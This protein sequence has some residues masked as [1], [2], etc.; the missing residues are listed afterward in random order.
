MKVTKWRMGILTT[1]GAL[2]LS[3]G[4]STETSSYSPEQMINNALEEEENPNY[5]GESLMEIYDNGEMIEKMRMKEWR[6]KD[7]KIR[8]ETTDESEKDKVIVVNDGQTITTYDKKEKQ[9]TIIDDKEIIEFNQ[10]SPKEQANA[11][12]EMIQETHEITSEGDEKIA[13]RNTFHLVAKP[14]EKSSLLGKQELWID[15]ENWM[16]LK[17]YSTSGNQTSKAI[18]TKIDVGATIP[19]KKFALHLA[20]DV[21]IKN[22]NEL[23]KMKT[24]TLQQAREGLDTPF[25]Y[26]PE[27]NGMEISTIEQDDLTGLVERTE[28]NI[29]YNKEDVPFLTLSVFESPKEE[30]ETYTLP[31]EESVT[32]RNHEGSFIDMEGFRNLVW[33]EEG[34]TYSILIIDPSIPLEKLLQATEK[35][36][37]VK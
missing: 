26:F 3:S 16:V 29:N 21:E 12:L 11:I 9:A 27:E 35:M 32:V 24:V 17:M 5:Y 30:D 34:L 2:I 31:E 23:N 6:S 1:F 7:G 18:Y 15:K 25:L 19:E 4:C 8:I 10:P 13:G 28:I 20:E 36:Q 14:K 33:Q 37:I 22:L